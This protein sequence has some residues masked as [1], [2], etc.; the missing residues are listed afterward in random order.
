MSEFFR[1]HRFKFFRMQNHVFAG[2]LKIFLSF[3]LPE[4]CSA[5]WQRDKLATFTVGVDLE[6]RGWG[7][8]GVQRGVQKWFG[9]A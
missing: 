2:L 9:G 5:L 1:M 4:F 8:T 7:A 6:E 3:A